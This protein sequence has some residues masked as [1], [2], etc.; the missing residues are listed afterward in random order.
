MTQNSRIH[1][2]NP[3]K[4]PRFLNQVPTLCELQSW[5]WLRVKDQ[6]DLGLRGERCSDDVSH[7]GMKAVTLNWP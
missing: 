5:G 2:R 7:A 1:I 4:G 6:G 3:D